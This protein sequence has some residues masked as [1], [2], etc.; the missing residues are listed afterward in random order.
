[1]KCMKKWDIASM[2]EKEKEIRACG[3]DVCVMQKI[4]VA[5]LFVLTIF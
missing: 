2:R 5:L 4:G 3:L 1:M